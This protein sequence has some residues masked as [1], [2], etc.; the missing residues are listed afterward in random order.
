MELLRRRLLA[1]VPWL[2]MAAPVHALMAGAAPDSPEAR[3]DANTPSSPWT[4]AVAVLTPGGVFSGVVVAP[5][6]VLTASH[7]TGGAAPG[8]VSVQLNHEATP[9]QIGAAAVT[10]FPGASFPYDD[11]S[12]ITLAS[13][14]PEGVEILPIYREAPST[15]PVLTLVGYGASG[16]GDVGIGVR[17]SAGIKRVGR[18]VLDEVQKRVDGSGRQSLF[19]LYDFDGPS[20]TGPLGGPGLG[21]AVETGVAGGDSGAAAYAEI[22]GR[23]WLLGISTVTLSASPGQAVDFRFGTIGGGMLLSDPR[24]LAWLETQ[25]GGTL[26]PVPQPELLPVWTLG[27]A[28]AVGLAAVLAGRRRR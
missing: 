16:Q 24:F 7:V 8:T 19:F 13:P 22:G 28:A 20:G 14:V 6:F 23:R 15:R 27:A 17:A 3:I 1:A 9:L 25:T 2:A 26:A 4:A 18:N 11:L 10:P 12:L 5:R 21:N